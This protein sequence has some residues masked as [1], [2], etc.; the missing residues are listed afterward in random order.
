M[1]WFRSEPMEY[2]SLIMNEDVAHACVAELGT[3]GIIQ[4]TD[5]RVLPSCGGISLFVFVV[6]LVIFVLCF[7]FESFGT[8]EG[9][10]KKR[11][12]LSRSRT[13]RTKNEKKEPTEHP[14]AIEYDRD[15]PKLRI[16]QT[17]LQSTYGRL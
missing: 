16:R 17:K 2:M 13:R 14:P 12:N 15:N 6:L 1:K 5:V 11:R 4:F 8:E 7:S 9:G 3:A 10:K